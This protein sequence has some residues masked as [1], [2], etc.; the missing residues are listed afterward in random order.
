MEGYHAVAETVGFIPNPRG[1]D[2][3]W[4]AVSAVA[5]GMIG[6]GL[7]ALLLPGAI[8]CDQLIGGGLGALGGLIAAVLVSGLVLIVLG[9]VRAINRIASK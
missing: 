4:Q 8:G 3:L 6:A 1:K 9:W 5:G 2:N 7:G